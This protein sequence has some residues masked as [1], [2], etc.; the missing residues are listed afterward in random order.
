MWFFIWEK[1]FSGFLIGMNDFVEPWVHSR[2]RE[3]FYI[4]N[5]ESRIDELF[6]YYLLAS[7]SKRRLD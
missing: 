4:Q 7:Q 5:P 3:E 2:A 6:K 1:L